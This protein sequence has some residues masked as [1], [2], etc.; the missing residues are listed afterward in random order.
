MLIVYFLI[1]QSGLRPGNLVR[2]TIGNGGLSFVDGR[3]Q[4]AD[5]HYL[6]KPNRAR[7]FA[8]SYSKVG[9]L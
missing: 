7:A 1:F 4:T 9:G 2:F 8:D 3:L 6:D 5:L